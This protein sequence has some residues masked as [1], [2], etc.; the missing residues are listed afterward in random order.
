MNTDKQHISFATSTSSSAFTFAEP[1][2]ATGSSVVE[3]NEQPHAGG[4][5]RRRAIEGAVYAHIRAVRAL[6]RQE[7][8]TVEIASALGLPQRDVEDAVA[9]LASKGVKKVHP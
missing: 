6:G 9:A 3:S 8:N 2:A 4:R 7:I 1:T 5:A